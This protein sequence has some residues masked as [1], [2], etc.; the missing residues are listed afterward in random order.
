M[1]AAVKNL[2][3]FWEGGEKINEY[4]QNAS[5]A[6]SNGKGVKKMLRLQGEGRTRTPTNAYWLR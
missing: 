4:E 3:C 2:A 6:W 5:S 1:S